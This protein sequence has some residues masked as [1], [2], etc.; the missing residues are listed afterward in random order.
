MQLPPDNE[1]WASF[2]KGDRVA[3]AWIYNRNIEELLRYG[4]R[5]TSNRQLIKDSIHDL[6]LHLWLHRENLSK[7]D[8]IRFYLFR[9]L[10]NRIIQNTDAPT[11]SGID[12]DLLLDKV[13][14]ELPLEHAIIEQENQ[15][16]QIKVLKKA[17]DRLPKRQQEVIQLRYFHDFTL[18][19]IAVVMQ[20]N[21]QSVRNLIHRSI[22]QLKIFFELAG[23]LLL[24]LFNNIGK[25]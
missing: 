21:N 3:F 24:L 1:L 11:V 2:L 12:M 19:E 17:I 9:S 4:Y 13:F 6:F 20:I 25:N 23:W 14:S 15:E 5:V 18:D 7:T 8:N 16:D 22:S 10:R